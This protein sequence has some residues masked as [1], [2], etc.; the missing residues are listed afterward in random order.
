[1][2]SHLL[3]LFLFSMILASCNLTFE[4]GIEPLQSS[5]TRLSAPSI[6]TLIPPPTATGTPVEHN[7]RDDFSG[8]LQDGWTWVNEIPDLWTITSSGWLQIIGQDPSLIRD[9][10]TNLLCRPAPSGEYQVT[11]HLYAEPIENFQQATLYLYQD[12]ENYIAINRGY[13]GSCLEGGSGVY[14]EYKKSGIFETFM[15][16]TKD[17]DVYLQLVSQYDEV[18][19]YY[20]L[21]LDF[22]RRLGS[23]GN[24]LEEPQVCLGVS[25]V[26]LDGID[27][28]LVGRFDYIEISL[29]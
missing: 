20:A 25:N 29:H 13:C 23:I 21:A 17:P 18:T 19:S 2:K 6:A 5:P 12:V 3:T 27:N 9:F 14:M 15:I 7:F 4:L 11:V 24:Y 28:D 16:G 22:W 8:N 10:Q 26:D 1:M